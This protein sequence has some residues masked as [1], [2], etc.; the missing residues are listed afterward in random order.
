MQAAAQ[1]HRR[2][3]LLCHRTANEDVPENT[4]ESLEQAALLGCDVVEIDIRRTLDGTIVLN[5]DGFLDRLSDGVGEVEETYYDDLSL[6]DMGG[7]MG[8]RFAGMHIALFEDALRLARDYHLRLYLDF[9][10]K[11]MGADVLRL[12]KREG[13][14]DQVRFGEGASP[15]RSSRP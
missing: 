15:N 13:M 10:G 4:L 12:L 6:R 9:K 7:W 14:L 2:V 3:E 1:Q 5:H 8:D 11:G